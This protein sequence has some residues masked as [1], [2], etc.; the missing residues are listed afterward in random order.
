VKISPVPWVLVAALPPLRAAAP[1]VGD[2]VAVVLPPLRWI[3]T[4]DEVRHRLSGGEARC[5][6]Y[7]LVPAEHVKAKVMVDKA[8]QR[9]QQLAGVICYVCGGPISPTEKWHLDHV[10]PL[11]VGGRHCLDNLELVHRDCNLLKGASDVYS[12]PV[13][14]D[15]VPLLTRL[16]A[17][18]PEDLWGFD[19]HLARTVLIVPRPIGVDASIGQLKHARAVVE[20]LRNQSGGWPYAAMSLSELQQNIPAI[21]SAGQLY[22]SFYY[23]LM[24]FSI[25]GRAYGGP[26]AEFHDKRLPPHPLLVPTR[27]GRGQGRWGV[28]GVRLRASASLEAIDRYVASGEVINDALNGRFPDVDIRPQ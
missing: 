2:Y 4:E 5:Q 23:K 17:M 3:P 19:L 25:K 13:G 10:R 16:R 27:V 8:S 9:S 21:T 28:A 15:I 14:A 24:G 26:G 12:P 20:V 1:G 18:Q 11:V 22:N 7:N 6:R